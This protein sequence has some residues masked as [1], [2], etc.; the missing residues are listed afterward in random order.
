MLPV[1]AGSQ[2]DKLS[3]TSWYFSPGEREGGGTCT[4]CT[5][6]AT[7]TSVNKFDLIKI[8]ARV[9]LVRNRASFF[10]RRLSDNIAVTEM[11]QG[12]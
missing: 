8:G 2:A 5:S 10:S 9:R 12:V 3:K 7:P 4:P 6:L 1:I 11:S